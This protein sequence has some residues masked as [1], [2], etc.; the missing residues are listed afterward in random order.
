MMESAAPQASQPSILLSARREKLA[1]VPG[2]ADT[3]EL[4]MLPPVG[5]SVSSSSSWKCQQCTSRPQDT[6]PRLNP[7]GLLRGCPAA[8]PEVLHV[9]NTW[10]PRKLPV[11]KPVFH[12]K[13]VTSG[14]QDPGP[15]VS[16]FCLGSGTVPGVAKCICRVSE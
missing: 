1:L 11:Y 8:P 5:E 6:L 12:S 14:G 10:C 16:A 7:S 15:W 13:L 4:L 3:G 2:L 9:W